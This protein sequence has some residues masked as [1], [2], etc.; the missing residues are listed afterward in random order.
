MGMPWLGER[1]RKLA[2]YDTADVD[3][4]MGNGRNC[5]IPACLLTLHYT[6]EPATDMTVL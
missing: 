2:C 1:W 5:A 4:T 6:E 3:V